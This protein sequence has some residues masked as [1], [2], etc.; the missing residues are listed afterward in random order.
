MRH[1][2]IIN[3]NSLQGDFFTSFWN[4]PGKGVLDRIIGTIKACFQ[5][6][7]ENA[8]TIHLSRYP[9]DAVGF[10]RSFKVD[11][12]PS[13]TLRVYAV[14]GNGILFD[15]LNGIMGLENTELAI[16]PYGI[17]NDMVQTFGD[18]KA[19]LFRNIAA[20]IASG[21]IPTD[22]ISCGSSFAINFC[23]LG[24]K[25]TLIKTAIDRYS[26]LTHH[27]NRFH[28]IDVLIY[29]FLL[30]LES[31]KAIFNPALRDQYYT[32]TVDGEDLSGRYGSIN[33]A[34]GACYG[35]NK[36]PA[37]TAIPDDGLLDILFFPS[38]TLLK[39]IRLVLPYIFGKYQQFPEEFTWKRGHRIHIHS[40][41]PLLVCL[42]GEAF[43]DTSLNVDIVPSGVRIVVPGES[44]YKKRA[45]WHEMA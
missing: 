5:E 26:S 12:D 41:T 45:E 7:Q 13:E 3:P 19:L 34:N 4:R 16:V 43:Y 31:F 37:I 36:S 14:G 15:C 1:L 30:Y 2:F 11:C 35:R 20:Q 44:R 27:S 40:D 17:S 18:N 9:R 28:S 6:D 23:V 29:G 25:S 38:R 22:V 10:I 8:Y 24:M 21:T 39:A 42:D 32:V 33:I